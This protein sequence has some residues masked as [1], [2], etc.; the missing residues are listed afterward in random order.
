MNKGSAYIPEGAI[1]PHHVD[2]VKYRREYN[3][4]RRKH[5]KHFRIQKANNLKKMRAK[6]A[7]VPMNEIQEKE[8]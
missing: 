6:R 7:S 1:T 8:R 2:P 5:D 3:E 4:Y